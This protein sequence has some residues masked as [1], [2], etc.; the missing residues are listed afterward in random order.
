MM[1]SQ[2]RRHAVVCPR[3]ALLRCLARCLLLAAVC[4]QAGPIPGWAAELEPPV[5]IL[6]GGRQMDVQLLGHAAPCV[7][8][9]NGDGRR[10]LLVG[11]LYR[12]RLRIYPNVG[13]NERPVFQDFELFL[14]GTPSGCIP[15]G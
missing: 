15:A 1:K 7:A 3:V 6:S 2:P 12:G 8:D 4:L 14:D 11:E 9:W 10:D 5:P 13:T